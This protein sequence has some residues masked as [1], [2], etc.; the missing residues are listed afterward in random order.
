MMKGIKGSACLFLFI[1]FTTSLYSE[2]AA[3]ALLQKARLRPT[4]QP[5]LLSAQIRGGEEPLPLTFQ[6]GKGQITYYLH[7]PEE[8]IILKLG[9]SS[10][11]LT[12]QKADYSKTL[13]NGNRYQ[14]VR[15]TGVTYDD[16]SLSFLYWPHPHLKGTET[17]RGTKTSILELTA[18]PLEKTPY[19]A[20]RIWIDQNSD[21]P[22][23][24]EA[25][26]QNGQLIKRFEVISAQKIEGLWMLKEM[27]IESFD[28]IT[29][30]IL[31]RRYLT[32]T[33][34]LSTKAT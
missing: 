13:E 4:A 18:P 23:R 1:A 30:R 21:A 31:Q 26:N 12:D 28:P 32:I 3:E 5:L 11:S 10:S 22:L 34:H 14:E 33:P 25:F 2:P 20:A 17:I 24:M 6:I 7:N 15:G 9:L 29:Q 19:G 16:L 8:A 27:R